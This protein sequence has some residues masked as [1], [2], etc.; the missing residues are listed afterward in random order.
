M[1]LLSRKRLVAD[2][3][4]AAD[5]VRRLWDEH[6][7]SRPAAKTLLWNVLMFQAWKEH[8]RLWADRQEPD[9]VHHARARTTRRHHG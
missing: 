7:H 3:I 4:F 8:Y 1:G 5:E 2:G 9:R 6:E